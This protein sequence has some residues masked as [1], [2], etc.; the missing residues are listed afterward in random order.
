M[1]IVSV[2]DNDLIII[3]PDNINDAVSILF[4]KFPSNMYLISP[5]HEITE[6]DESI[7]V[8]LDQLGEWIIVPKKDFSAIL[9]LIWS[10]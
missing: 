9:V 8:D 10:Y 7:P 1:R 4:Q 2:G 3:R 5:D 6:V